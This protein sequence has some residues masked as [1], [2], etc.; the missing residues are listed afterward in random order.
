MLEAAMC[1]SVWLAEVAETG[2]GNRQNEIVVGVDHNGLTMK[3]VRVVRLRSVAA[4]LQSQSS[5][6]GLGNTS[7]RQ[8][9]LVDGESV[10]DSHSCFDRCC[11]LDGSRL[12]SHAS[13]G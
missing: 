5:L 9:L 2:R 11:Q 1:R 12:L 13:S 7:S 6:A 10:S 4:R 3:P 8:R